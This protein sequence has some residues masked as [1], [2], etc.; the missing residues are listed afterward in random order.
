MRPKR[1]TNPKKQSQLGPK[2][3]EPATAPVQSAVPPVAPADSLAFVQWCGTQLDLQPPDGRRIGQNN[4]LRP[5]TWREY[6]MYHL[7]RIRNK[8]G[9]LSHLALN[10]AQQDLEATSGQRNIV[11]KARQLGVTTYVAAR[12]FINCIT[13]EG[14]LSVQVAHDQRS[15]EEIFRIVH[16]LLEN[17]PEE[18]RK[19]ALTTSRA[20]VRQIVFP[21]LEAIFG[22]QSGADKKT[23]ALSFLQAAIS[24]TDDVGKS[25][26]DRDK[27][28]NGLSKVIDGVV[29]CLNAS[30]WATQH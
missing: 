14:T 17:L 9:R 23:A 10:R 1:K 25:I 16:R 29:E 20:N 28:E 3:V 6:L 4:S 15:A 12:F 13:R 18:L 24:V 2:L 8:H 11:L 22:P 19:G 5:T 7:L 21:V 27:F 30:V 26:V